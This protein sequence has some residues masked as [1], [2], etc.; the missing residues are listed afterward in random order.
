MTPTFITFKDYTGRYWKALALIA[1][2][3]SDRVDSINLADTQSLRLKI[4]NLRIL[5]GGS[6]SVSR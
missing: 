4:S 3:E 2:L 5:G 1:P 6:N